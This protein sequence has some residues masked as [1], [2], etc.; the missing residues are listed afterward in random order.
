M[1]P[2]RIIIT[3]TYSAHSVMASIILTACDPLVGSGAGRLTNDV[4]KRSTTSAGSLH[5]EGEGVLSVGLMDLIGVITG[6]LTECC[7]VNGCSMNGSDAGATGSSSHS[8][9]LKPA[10]VQYMQ[11]TRVI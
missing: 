1:I 8:A 5:R 3:Q 9:P 10:T 2:Q 11:H 7:S 4:I 6:V